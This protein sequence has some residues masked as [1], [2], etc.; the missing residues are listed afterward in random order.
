MELIK[1]FMIK[2]QKNYD[3]DTLPATKRDEL[4]LDAKKLVKQDKKVTLNQNSSQAS[5]LIPNDSIKFTNS[6]DHNLS[7]STDSLFQ[8]TPSVQKFDP[9]KLADQNIRLNSESPEDSLP[10]TS[11]S[12]IPKMR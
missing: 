8:E 4:A 11:G 10:Q 2:E 7:K 3:Q 9:V 1:K 12:G 6:I 5:R